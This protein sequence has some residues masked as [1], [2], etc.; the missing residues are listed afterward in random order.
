MD[1]RGLIPSIPIFV[2]IFEPFAIVAA[3]H[4]PVAQP[5]TVIT[6]SVPISAEVRVISMPS[7]STVVAPLLRSFVVAGIKRRLAKLIRATPVWITVPAI[8]ALGRNTRS[9]SD[10]NSNQQERDYRELIDLK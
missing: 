4:L 9:R 7:S 1:S 2:A 5:R 10:S 3:V 8:S 6:R